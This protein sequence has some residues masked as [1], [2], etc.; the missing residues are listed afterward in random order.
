[1]HVILNSMKLVLGSQSPRRKEILEFFSIPFTQANPSFDESS[2]P[3]N[4]DPEDYV[5]SLS[6]GKSETLVDQ[7]P[8]STILTAD[9]IV[10]REG[11]VYGKP[12]DKEEAFQ[13]LSELAGNWHSVYTG[14]TLQNREKTV[15][16]AEVTRVLFNDLSPEQIHHYLAQINW[17][18]KAGSYAI[19]MSGGIIIRKIDGCYYNVKG[20]PINIVEDLLKH[21][22]VV[23]WEHL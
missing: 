1:M 19:Q 3:F 21:F 16:K 12:K 10:F 15:S 20:L 5:C 23:L 8:D 11:K 4:G 7:Y 17:A 2:L 22:D 13:F 6:K 18:D 14:V 9:T